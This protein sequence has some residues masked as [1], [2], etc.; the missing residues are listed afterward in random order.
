MRIYLSEMSD[1]GAVHDYGPDIYTEADGEDDTLANLGPLRPLAGVWTSAVG[2]DV[3]PIGPGSDISG[4]VV[5]GN[6]HNAFVE[7]YELQPVDRQTNGPQLFY[8]LRYHTHIVKPGEVET[9]HDQVGYWLWEPAARTVVHTLAIPRGQVLLAAGHA[10]PDDKEFEVTAALGSEVCGILSN[11][12]LD[13]AFRTVSFRIRVTVSD[14]GTWSYEEHT[15]IRIPDRDALVDHV[16]RNT[17]RR[18]GEP[19]PNPLAAGASTAL[20]T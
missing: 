1:E 12:F 10:E 2:A 4:D 17:L 5:E 16:D 18:I 6:E 19:M 14:D 13:R 7:R 9:F 20:E 8:G 15:S 11:P 3:H